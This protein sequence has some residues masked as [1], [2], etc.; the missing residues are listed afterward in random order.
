MAWLRIPIRDRLNFFF[1]AEDG[2]RDV[3]VTGVQTCAL[4]IFV[5]VES[6]SLNSCPARR[7]IPIVA[8]YPGLA[9]LKRDWKGFPGAGSGL[10]TIWKES[11]SKPPP[12]GRSATK[13]AE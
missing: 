10:P 6:R 13:A 8:K 12:R 11:E 1:Q 7:G 4:P 9:T 3:A 5:S 2:I